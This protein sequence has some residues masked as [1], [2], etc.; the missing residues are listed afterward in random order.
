MGASAFSVGDMTSLHVDYYIP[1]VLLAILHVSFYL[2]LEKRL[3]GRSYK[4]H[5]VASIFS[6]REAQKFSINS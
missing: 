1:G 3:R 2:P 5:F 6:F 4:L